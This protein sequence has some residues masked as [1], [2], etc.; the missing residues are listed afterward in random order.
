MR[1]IAH[2]RR[3]AAW[4]LVLVYMPMLV[5]ISVHHH[6]EAD[7]DADAPYCYDCEHHIHHEGHISEGHAPAHFCVLCHLH[8]LPYF[9]ASAFKTAD[10]ADAHRVA[11][12]AHN[13][14]VNTR[15][16]YSYPSRAPP[17]SLSL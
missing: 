1:D 4:L 8:L 13:P 9:A 7:G 14:L 12:K 10:I 17:A 16:G 11:F 3:L 15:G 2:R 6:S 5:A